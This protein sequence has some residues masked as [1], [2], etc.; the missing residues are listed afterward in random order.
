LVNGQPQRKT[1]VTGSSNDTMIEIV[2]GVDEGE[3]IISQTINSSATNSQS[4]QGGQQG[5]GGEFRMLR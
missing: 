5:F 4:T 1:V 3:E 2:S